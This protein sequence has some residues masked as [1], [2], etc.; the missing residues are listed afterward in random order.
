MSANIKS[1]LEGYKDINVKENDKLREVLQQAALLG[2]YRTHFFEHAAFYGGTA[3]RILYG[4]NRFSEDLDFSLLKSSPQFDFNPF[5]E[6]LEKEMGSMGF[7][8][9]VSEKE[10]KQSTGILFSILKNKHFG[11]IVGH[12]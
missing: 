7:K 11:F 1:M 2:L 5:L 8:V 3:L 12:S 4:L 6:G 10:K 9:E